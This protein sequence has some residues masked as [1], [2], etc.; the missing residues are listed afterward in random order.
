M[1]ERAFGPF[2]YTDK[3]AVRLYRLHFDTPHTTVSDPP[4]LVSTDVE[5]VW[6]R[7]LAGFKE[8]EVDL[9]RS[10]TIYSSGLHRYAQAGKVPDFT[11]VS[12]GY[13]L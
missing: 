2:S 9:A 5:D 3:D 4:P 7:D 6:D 10:Y 12:L 11:E 8:W 13:V 1:D